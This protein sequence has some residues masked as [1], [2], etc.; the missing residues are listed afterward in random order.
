MLI[1]RTCRALPGALAMASIMAYATAANG[2]VSGSQTSDL[3]EQV[4][5]VKAE[6]MALR[7]QVRAIEEQQRVLLDLINQLRRRIDGSQTDST[8]ALTAAAN[9]SAPVT[10]AA[11]ASASPAAAEKQDKDDHYQDGIVIWQNPEDAKIPFLLK[12]NNNTQIRY[13]NTLDS[14]DTFTDHLGTVREVHRPE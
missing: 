4:S 6:N 13:L 1:L 7:Q 12:F 5:A 9:A 11:A 14:S 2:Q 10:S 3:E 8:P